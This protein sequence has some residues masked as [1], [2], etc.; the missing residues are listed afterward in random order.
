MQNAARSRN[1]EA[2][3]K[4][5][6]RGKQKGAGNLFPRNN[7]GW[8]GWGSPVTIFAQLPPPPPPP[9]KKSPNNV[10]TPCHSETT[11]TTLADNSPKAPSIPS[12]ML[13]SQST[14]AGSLFCPPPLSSS[15]QHCWSIQMIIS[16]PTNPPHS[17][18]T[19]T[20]FAIFIPRGQ[21][22]WWKWSNARFL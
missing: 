12:A 5:G 22:V 8:G 4:A 9:L 7:K 10:R 1:C 19:S 16:H 14:P 11:S 15:G 17:R 6:E 13:E 3:G 21:I 2:R 18:N 20:W